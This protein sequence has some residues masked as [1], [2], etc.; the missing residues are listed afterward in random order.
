MAPQVDLDNLLAERAAG[1]VDDHINAL[2]FRNDG[3][4]YSQHLKEMGNVDALSSHSLLL[5]YLCSEGGGQFIS[6]DGLVASLP[7]PKVIDLPE[8]VLPSSYEL[9][10]AL[11]TITIDPGLN[12]LVCAALG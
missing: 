6:K 1:K 9:D 7:A 11:Q 12:K 10:R 3:Y 5:N 2:G 4:D 8:D